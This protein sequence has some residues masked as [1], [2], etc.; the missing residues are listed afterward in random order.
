SLIAT[1]TEPDRPVQ[2]MTAE[3]DQLRVRK[4]DQV[5]A[6][7]AS[8]NRT[9]Q[10]ESLRRA[11]GKEIGFEDRAQDRKVLTGRDQESVAVGLRPERLVAKRERDHRDPGA[12]DLAHSL[13][14]FDVKI[15]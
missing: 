15:A 10:E 5:G 1:P 3:P 4:R 13:R 7:D 12:R 14:G 6:L 11:S 2:G 9:H 8:Q